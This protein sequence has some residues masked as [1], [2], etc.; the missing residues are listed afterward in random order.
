MK[1]LVKV[2]ALLAL[3]SAIAATAQAQEIVLGQVASTGSVSSRGIATN[4]NLGY[5]I[6]FEKLNQQGG[7]NGNKIKLVLK[8]DGLKIENMVQLTKE[9]IADKSVIGLVGYLNT[10]GMVE[11]T[12]LKVLPE[13]GMAL[14]SPHQGDRPLV[15]QPN[16]FPFR[17][18]FS[19]EIVTIIREAK[20]TQKQRL[21]IL[22]QATTMG[23]PNA[24]LAE[25]EAKKVGLPIVGKV[26]FEP[27]NL[28]KREAS[29]KAAVEQ[30]VKSKADAILLISAGAPGFLVISALRDSP[31]EP[32]IVYAMSVTQVSDLPPSIPMSKVHGTVIAQSVPYPF[33][34]LI[35]AVR[36]YQKLMKEF[37][38]D[39]PYDYFSMEGF[40]GA[41]ITHEALKRAGKKPTRESFLKALKTMGEIDLGGVTVNYTEKARLG[42]GGVDLT[43]I[44]RNGR[45][46]R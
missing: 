34:G 44:D 26:S 19:D 41:K 5:R 20:Q 15:T 17:S 14:V 7:V 21:F 23:P 10:P 18:G 11:L 40:M 13:G 1:K 16:I 24:A 4:I 33:S 28:E 9:F 32:H 43:I 6:Y 30:V 8:D 42:W 12:K 45:P 46:V 25:A 31:A 38:P 39:K 29:I 37:A 2:L 36:E 3:P 27:L 22:H 35:P